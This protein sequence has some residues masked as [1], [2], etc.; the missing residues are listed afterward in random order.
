MLTSA[1][2][3][4]AMMAIAA[5]PDRASRLAIFIGTVAPPSTNPPPQW[6]VSFADADQA[7]QWFKQGGEPPEN[8]ANIFDVPP[9]DFLSEWLK[10]GLVGVSDGSGAE[11]ED[12]MMPL[13]G[14][15]ARKRLW[16]DHVIR[17]HFYDATQEFR[18]AAEPPQ[19]LTRLDTAGFVV[20]TDGNDVADPAWVVSRLRL[21]AT[22]AWT[23]FATRAPNRTE[24][25][26]YRVACHLPIA[27]NAHAAADNDDGRAK[28]YDTR[29]IF[30]AEAVRQDQLGALW[31]TAGDRS[32]AFRAI[33][34]RFSDVD[35]MTPSSPVVPG[36]LRGRTYAL[37][38]LI[39]SDQAY[40]TDP[41]DA[42][43][44]PLFASVEQ[45]SETKPT[46]LIALRRQIGLR[47]IANEHQLVLRAELHLALTDLDHWT[48]L[49]D[50]LAGN[51][52]GLDR[53]NGLRVS[54][55]DA[56]LLLAQEQLVDHLATDFGAVLPAEWRVTVRVE[57]TDSDSGGGDTIERILARVIEKAQILAKSPLRALRPESG[58]STIPAIDVNGAKPLA[59]YLVGG[60]KSKSTDRRIFKSSGGATPWWVAR[61]EGEEPG[62]RS[63]QPVRADDVWKASPKWRT[64]PVEL[65]LSTI[66]CVDGAA[67]KLVR[68][69]TAV[70][71]AIDDSREPTKQPELDDGICFQL[72]GALPAGPSAQQVRIGAFQFSLL[73]RSSFVQ[74]FRMVLNRDA[75]SLARSLRLGTR[76][77]VVSAEPIE[78]DRIGGR[79]RIGESL[80]GPVLIRLGDRIQ[81]MKALELV[82][83]E[84]FKA[85]FDQQVEWS[86]RGPLS[87]SFGKLLII[88][89]QPF[90]VAAVDY[91]FKPDPDNNEIA[92]WRRSDDGN[93]AW[94]VRDPAETVRMLLPP[95][96]IGEAMERQVDGPN[97]A[98]NDIAPDAPATSR[99]GSLTRIDFDPTYRETA[100][101]EPS[102]NLRR[103]LGR[104]A[105]AVPGALI[106]DVRFEIA[107][108][109]IARH[110][111]QRET[112]LAEMSGIMGAAPDALEA[113]GR[114]HL[115]IKHGNEVL[116][117]AD[118]RLAVDKIW[119]GRPERRFETNEALTFFLRTRAK[120][121]A[122]GPA[123]KL[124]YPVPGR[125]PDESEATAV[126]RLRETFQDPGDPQTSSFAGGVS[127]A[128]ES[129]NILEEAYEQPVTTEGRISDIFFS[130]LGGWG[131]QRAA[132]AQG[133]SIIETET[134][135][136]RLSVYK[137]ERLGRI[138]GLGHRA[139]HVI[140]YRRTV[141]PSAQFYNNESI[142]T[143]QDDHAGR[144]I[145][146]KVEEYVDILEPERHYPEKGSGTREPGCLSGARFISRRIR[147]DSDWGGDVRNEGWMVPLWRADMVNT[148]TNADTKDPDSPAN[149][150]PKPL[151]QLLMPAESDE[152]VPVAVDTPERLVFYTS[153]IEGETADNIDDWHAVES[154]DFC[155][156]PPP[157]VEAVPPSS[158]ALHDGMLPPAPR[159][160]GGHDPLTLGLVNGQVPIRIGAGRT[161][162]G[163]AA[164]LKNI[165]ISRAMPRAV[166]DQNKDH[167]AVAAQR[168]GDEAGCFAADL[169]AKFD[170]MFGKVAARFETL[171]REA[172]GGRD[173]ALQA[174]KDTR[175]ELKAEL[176][177]LRVNLDQEAKKFT[178]KL[179]EVKNFKPTEL[180]D[181]LSSA[182]RSD[183]IKE[184][185]GL[186]SRAIGAIALASADLLARSQD[187]SQ[188]WSIE[189]DTAIGQWEKV[190]V[191]K[192]IAELRK[193]ARALLDGQVLR[194]LQ[195][196][197]DDT[198]HA[199]TEIK[200]LLTRV[201]PSLDKLTRLLDLRPE[202]QQ[203]RGEITAALAKACGDIVEARKAI[204]AWQPFGSDAEVKAKRAELHA[205]AAKS[206][207]SLLD[208]AGRL[209]GM[210]AASG[211]KPNVV[212][213]INETV[214]SLRAFETYLG[215]LDREAEAF[216]FP[217]T[218]FLGLLRRLDTLA[219]QLGNGVRHVADEVDGLIL[220]AIQKDAELLAQ[221]GQVADQLRHDIWTVIL[222]PLATAADT[223]AT[224]L[225]KARK[226]A[227]AFL[228]A[229]DIA[230][231]EAAKAAHDLAATLKGQI[232]D[233]IRNA[234]A[235]AQDAV[236]DIEQAMREG[237]DSTDKALGKVIYE[238]A[239][240]VR[241]YLIDVGTVTAPAQGVAEE[242]RKQIA[243]PL[244]AATTAEQEIDA[245]IDAFAEALIATINSLA[246]EVDK[247]RSA[248]EA[249][250]AD[251]A[252][253]IAGR[254]ECYLGGVERELARQLGVQPG[255]LV[256]GVVASVDKAHYLYQEGDNVL[257]LIRAVGDPPK[258]DALGFNR[259]EVAYVFDVLKSV[260]DVTPV[261]ALANRVTDTTA[262]IQQAAGAAGKLLESFGIRLPVGSLGED[263]IPDKLKDL[264]LGKLFP[265]F[266]GL[267][268]ESLLKNAGFPDLSGKDSQ[269]VKIT[270]G[271]DRDRREAWLRAEID[272]K[273]SK[274]S[275]ILDI[276]PI[277]LMIDEGQFRA[278][279]RVAMGA[280][281]RFEK[282]AKGQIAGDWRLVTAGMDII[283]FE[284][285]PL[286]FD[287]SGKID[288]KIAT[289]RVRLAPTLEFLTNL[290]AKVGKAMPAGVEPIMRDGIPAG[291]V[292]KLSMQLP[293]VQ[294]GAFAITDLSLAASFGIIAIPE[295]EIVCS[296]DIASRDA[297]FTL[298]VWLLNGGGY[299]T[300]RLSYRPMSRPK[301]ILTYT[302]D[303]AILAGV[304][305]G[306]GFGVVSGGV[307]LQVGCSVALS[308]T[309]G[310][311]SNVTT[312][313]AFLLARGNV[314]VAGLVSAN[315]MLRLEISYNGSTMVARG[316]LRLSFR[317]SM[318]YTL[319]VNQAAQY[320]LAGERRADP[321]ND[322]S[323]SFG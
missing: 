146:R 296:L 70:L 211:L 127:W 98:L 229:G 179:N 250:A 315:I 301:P 157:R 266:A 60:F 244:D 283:T 281:G 154:I 15:N 307:W 175:D 187:L 33:D 176:R 293:P 223:A 39:G 128:F 222:E 111:P 62:L 142:G 206:R 151:V 10:G 67:L 25:T 260:V 313:T 188:H 227:K 73:A 80:D 249:A 294:T 237:V 14:T 99:F 58:L 75:N 265:D 50:G 112:W 292:T 311:A 49:W 116:R 232:A 319:R 120:G 156:A 71:E 169:R 149:L 306:F 96:I 78:Q 105:D 320:H 23:D 180:A 22:V 233:K 89:P 125:Y 52:T 166:R 53:P 54:N 231:A 317:I 184:R 123:T 322:Y 1:P 55:S 145:L 2:A 288:F 245:Q 131:R 43:I 316:T 297:P 114:D 69:P 5:T 280:D 300:Q 164:T 66:T 63:F 47:R 267:N 246:D 273:L 255:D 61:R 218:D 163:P 7:D 167:P 152:E 155:D 216:V 207:R 11:L 32:P 194:A 201:E 221:F 153:T 118:H 91:G 228:E 170:Q 258:T 214:V 289:D 31:T 161:A 81:A 56:C 287:K 168:A 109:L 136:G 20:D 217:P 100:T 185:E 177:S 202:L 95:Q 17:I 59:W 65:D 276:G 74:T 148:A 205:A 274:S 28:Q 106:R 268:L 122:G 199:K 45:F 16:I 130:A 150:Y 103:V 88:D 41:T 44:A 85:D 86:F 129:A 139:K 203:V 79:R 48:P 110:Q 262:A 174:V 160:A 240:E 204:A 305:I 239:E 236:R 9:P 210:A 92:V 140:V 159:S 191:G 19:L 46:N 143:K 29:A 141:A 121:N 158:A 182:L 26:G 279:T 257:R 230:T 135:M 107:Y 173:R 171:G 323:E 192:S 181:K 309:T 87:P 282:E 4:V 13:T 235:T 271:F 254:L 269:G 144:P 82:G 290:M 321:A 6:F 212:A 138:G 242:L 213:K 278:E 215:E 117:L 219:V 12:R 21:D 291:L 18:F 101:R 132:F 34:L 308:W 270:R 94:R 256:N 252:R 36:G 40:R 220:V 312:V 93:F 37:T 183:L 133:K 57:Q 304:G 27:V 284:K 196:W 241:T 24:L 3:Y 277:A 209:Q 197:R 193:N 198:L 83:I 302:L 113:T 8:A 261:L 77:E 162:T 195:A 102:W 225:D 35:G 115:F 234:Q 119:S 165:T 42:A 272:V 253:R 200:A 68:T 299:V 226:D 126:Q 51:V 303:I 310:A 186:R 208:I 134:A 295:F 275:S 238:F 298:A 64:R 178:D 314:D 76:L 285:T 30:L 251:Q 172:L 224:V 124:R 247:V 38:D 189:L 263:L 318:F 104:I 90:R 248:I 72:Y 84:T 286:L 97:V 264:S 190:T 243:T 137:L 259:P 147:V 108:G